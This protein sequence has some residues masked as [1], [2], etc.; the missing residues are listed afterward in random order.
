MMMNSVKNSI[1]GKCLQV[2][3]IGYFLMSS[4]NISTGL[5]GLLSNNTELHSSSIMGH[6]LK[7][8]FKCNGCPEEIDDYEAKTKSNNGCKGSFV[9]DYLVPNQICDAAPYDQKHFQKKGCTCDVALQCKFHGKIHLPPP[10][11]LV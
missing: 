9:L 2:L 1:F 7:K 4:I 10:E 6:L 5:D 8:I 3:L 11:R